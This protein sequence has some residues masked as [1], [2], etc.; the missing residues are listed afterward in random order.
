MKNSIFWVI[1]PCSPLKANRRF[2]ERYCLH[3]Q[4]RRARVKYQQR[5]SRYRGGIFLRNVGW[6]SMHY[7]ALYMRRWCDELVFTG[8][9]GVSTG[10]LSKKHTRKWESRKV[11]LHFTFC[12]QLWLPIASISIFAIFPSVRI[13]VIMICLKLRANKAYVRF[14]VFVI[15]G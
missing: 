5:E 12:Y 11:R 15:R 13:S 2:G 8:H 10:I 9:E 1:E 3:L 14:T 4:G 6:L 7:T